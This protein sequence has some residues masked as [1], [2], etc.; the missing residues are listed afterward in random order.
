MFIGAC[1]IK[2]KVVHMEKNGSRG[3][4]AQC[5]MCCCYVCTGRYC[6]EGSRYDWQHVYKAHC[7]RCQLD[8]LRKVLDCD[9]FENY[10]TSARRFHFKVRRRREDAVIARLDALLEHFGVDKPGE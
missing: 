9:Y 10:H 4:N 7:R 5:H 2:V 8:N 1:F 6:P 3:W